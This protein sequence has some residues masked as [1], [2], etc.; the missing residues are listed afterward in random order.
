MEGVSYYAPRV[1]TPTLRTIGKY[2][3]AAAASYFLGNAANNI[4]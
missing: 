4:G 3:D 2:G 1:W